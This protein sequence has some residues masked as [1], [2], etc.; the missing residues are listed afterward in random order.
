MEFPLAAA[1]LDWDPAA[2]AVAVA[3]VAAVEAAVAE[4]VAAAVV[5]AAAAAEQQLLWACAMRAGRP[6]WLPRRSPRSCL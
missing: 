5:A 4:V 6:I 1:A 2:L 3:A